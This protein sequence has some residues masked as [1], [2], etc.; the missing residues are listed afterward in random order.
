MPGSEQPRP[1]GS[2]ETEWTREP[3]GIADLHL[4]I[5][6][7]DFYHRVRGERMNSY[8]EHDPG[9]IFNKL[10]PRVVEAGCYLIEWRT[11]LFDDPWNHSQ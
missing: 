11:L 5:G 6:D 1:L 3:V 9:Q 4:V 2:G 8:E 10:S 7:V